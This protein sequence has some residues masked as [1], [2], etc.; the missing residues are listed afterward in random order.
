MEHVKWTGSLY[1]A[2]IEGHGAF[3]SQHI[4]LYSLF[5][6]GYLAKA[7]KRSI[8]CCCSIRCLSL[9]LAAQLLPKLLTAFTC[10][11]I[12]FSRIWLLLFS[13]KGDSDIRRWCLCLLLLRL[14]LQGTGWSSTCLWTS[15]GINWYFFLAFFLYFT[16][17]FDFMICF[18]FVFFSAAC[19]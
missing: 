11:V 17:A 6:L 19:S 13:S 14:Q 9:M 7:C 4:V 5:F 1:P 8:K 15:G 16:T 18:N 12:R 3:C 2:F 10:C